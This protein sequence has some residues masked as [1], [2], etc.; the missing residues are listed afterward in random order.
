[1]SDSALTTVTLRRED[2]EAIQGYLKGIEVKLAQPPDRISKIR[3][4]DYAILRLSVLRL[5]EECLSIKPVEEEGKTSKIASLMR[6]CQ[7]EMRRSDGYCPNC[8][9]FVPPS[10]V[11]SEEKCEHDKVTWW[12]NPNSMSVDKGVLKRDSLICPFCPKPEERS[13]DG[14]EEVAINQIAINIVSKYLPTD[15]R[16]GLERAIEDAIRAERNRGG[17]K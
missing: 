15:P 11:K 5:V 6:P 17:G 8:W 12:R 9:S 3:I 4:R 10:P 1:M 14:S 7:H 2:W 16:R 13:P